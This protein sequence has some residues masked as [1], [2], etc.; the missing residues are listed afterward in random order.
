MIAGELDQGT[1][2]AMAQTMADGIADAHLVVLPDASHL[3][4]IEQPAAFRQ[5][6][7]GFIDGL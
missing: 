7:L 3:S 4:A 1:P 6:V 2:V 5:A